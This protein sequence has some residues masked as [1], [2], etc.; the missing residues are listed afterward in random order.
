MCIRDRSRIKDVIDVHEP[1]VA[2]YEVLTKFTEDRNQLDVSI[3]YVII[4][5]PPKF[6][7]IDIAFKP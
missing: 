1:R 6:D 4:G 5:V 7:N 2:V 3:A